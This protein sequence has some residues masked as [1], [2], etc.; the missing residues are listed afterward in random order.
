MAGTQRGV[1]PMGMGGNGQ[2]RK[3]RTVKAVASGLEQDANVEAII[4]PVPP[5]VPGT[6]G[7]WARNPRR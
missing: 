7:N 4:G 2:N 5:M 1:L 6:I 3:S